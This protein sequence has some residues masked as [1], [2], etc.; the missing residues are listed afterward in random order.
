MFFQDVAGDPQGVDKVCAHGNGNYPGQFYDITQ[1]RK[2]KVIAVPEKEQVHFRP[3]GH[4]AGD[5]RA[6]QITL[7]VGADNVRPVPGDIFFAEYFYGKGI[8]I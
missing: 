1:Q 3:E 6:V 5:Q 7:V 2:F 4:A 8:S